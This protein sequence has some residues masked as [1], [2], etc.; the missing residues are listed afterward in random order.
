[1]IFDIAH[2]TKTGMGNHLQAILLPVICSEDFFSWFQCT[3]Q[4]W[5]NFNPISEWPYVNY[6]SKGWNQE[7]KAYSWAVTAGR[8]YH[9]FSLSQIHQFRDLTRDST[10]YT[11]GIHHCKVACVKLKLPRHSQWQQCIKGQ[12]FCQVWQLRQ[13][14]YSIAR[15]TW[16]MP[17]V[18]DVTGSEKSPPGGETLSR[19]A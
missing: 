11:V 6:S 9:L 16:T 17:K 10:S 3:Y 18:A 13:K 14:G 4:G 1:M 15:P 19:K 5:F 8:N 12:P 2:F 7:A